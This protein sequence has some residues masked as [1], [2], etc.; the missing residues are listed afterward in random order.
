ML[1]FTQKYEYIHSD[2]YTAEM[3]QLS[4]KMDGKLE[5]QMI[6]KN[7]KDD[8]NDGMIY[9]AYYYPQALSLVCHTTCVQNEN[10]TPASTAY[11]VSD[12]G[13]LYPAKLV[14]NG[15]YNTTLLI[16]EDIPQDTVDRLSYLDI[17]PDEAATAASME[18]DPK[19][20]ISGRVR[21]PLQAV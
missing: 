12:T 7:C 2:L 9:S 15:E 10:T 1:Y 8:Q 13:V 21:Y 19:A 14:W 16:F 11:L 6:W 5:R 18:Y 4:S 17:L 3:S 20:T